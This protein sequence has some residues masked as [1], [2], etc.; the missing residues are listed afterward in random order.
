LDG[1]SY[2]ISIFIRYYFILIIIGTSMATP[3][4][5]GFASYVGTF[6]GTTD[7]DTVKAAIDKFASLHVVTN[8]KTDENNLPYD[9][10]TKEQVAKVNDMYKFLTGSN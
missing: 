5:A 9:V 1:R 4:I 2:P 8:A 3:L 10:L 6:L 7:P